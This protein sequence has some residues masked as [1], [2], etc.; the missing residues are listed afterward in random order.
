MERPSVY[1]V[2]KCQAL[3]KTL[4]FFV[5]SYGGSLVERRLTFLAQIDFWDWEMDE[6]MFAVQNFSKRAQAWIAGKGSL[7]ILLK[8]QGFVVKTKKLE[9]ALIDRHWVTKYR[10]QVKA[11]IRQLNKVIEKW[12]ELLVLCESLL[13]KDLERYGVVA[14]KDLSKYR[15]KE[16][17]PDEYPKVVEEDEEE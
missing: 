1:L 2:E 7:D 10:Q 13:Q 11:P 16:V 6:L 5:S 12:N 8:K 3:E 9:N 14:E 4:Q 17:D 15:K